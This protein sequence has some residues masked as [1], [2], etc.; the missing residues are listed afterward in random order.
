VQAS[1]PASGER[2]VVKQGNW[3][4]MLVDP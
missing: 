2:P 4:P 1:F 3:M